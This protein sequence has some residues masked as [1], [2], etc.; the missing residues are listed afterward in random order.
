MA[1]ATSCSR[2]GTSTSSEW[3]QLVSTKATKACRASA[4]LVIASRAMTS[5]TLRDS[6]ENR[7][8]WLLSAP[9]SLS[10]R[11]RGVLGKRVLVRV[12]LGGGVILTTNNRKTDER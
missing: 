5:R 6:L 2:R 11:R 3:S 7:S 1:P 12:D 8:S 10:D 9:A 4:K